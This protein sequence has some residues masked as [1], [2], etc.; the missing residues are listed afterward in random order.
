M[1]ILD[2][3]HQKSEA[4]GDT[5]SRDHIEA[6]VSRLEGPERRNSA[7]AGM[8]LG[9]LVREEAEQLRESIVEGCY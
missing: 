5:K 9:Q 7:R 2:R 3:L 8:D 4:E 1:G 6:L